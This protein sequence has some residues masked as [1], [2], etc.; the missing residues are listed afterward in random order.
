MNYQSLIKWSP[1]YWTQ[2]SALNNGFRRFACHRIAVDYLILNPL[3]SCIQVWKESLTS[4]AGD[5]KRCFIGFGL[6]RD[7]GLILALCHC[8]IQTKSH[9]SY[10]LFLSNLGVINMLILNS[11]YLARNF[12][13]SFR[14]LSH[15]MS[16][17]LWVIKAI[18]KGFLILKFSAI[19]SFIYPAVQT[20]SVRNTKIV[21]S[22]HFL[23]ERIFSPSFWDVFW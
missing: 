8:E 3:K 6:I 1:K 4:R 9:R 23:T 13:R 7:G 14:R 15:S 10:F 21:F 17:F 22:S 20:R 2:L 19:C 18:M 5:F 11:A 16:A 12:M